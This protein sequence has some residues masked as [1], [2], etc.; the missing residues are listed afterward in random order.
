MGIGQQFGEPGLLEVMI[1]GECLSQSSFVHDSKAHAIGQPP[2][3]V[4]ALAV[5]FPTF[6][7]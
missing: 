6:C 2:G 1:R 5:Q 7:K 3:L 4:A